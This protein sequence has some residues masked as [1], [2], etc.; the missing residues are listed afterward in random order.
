MRR[1]EKKICES[2]YLRDKALEAYPE[3][4]WMKMGKPKEIVSK[5]LIVNGTLN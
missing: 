5:T 4:C 3:E 1:T 2:V